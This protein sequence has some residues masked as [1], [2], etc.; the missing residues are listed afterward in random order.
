[1]SQFS[2]VNVIGAQNGQASE[3]A[4]QQAQIK[5]QT[6]QAQQLQLQGKQMATEAKLRQHEIDQRGQLQTQ[7]LS[8]QH[9]EAASGR[10]YEAAM[11]Q[12]KEQVELAHFAVEH[13]NQQDQYAFDMS[14]KMKLGLMTSQ[15]QN[16]LNE[17]HAKSTLA[18]SHYTGALTAYQMSKD[19]NVESWNHAFETLQGIRNARLQYDTQG[20]AASASGN[21]QTAGPIAGL[22]GSDPKAYVNFLR[23]RGAMMSLAA[24]QAKPGWQEGS[25]D[26]AEKQL[27]DLSVERNGQTAQST[28][29]R[30]AQAQQWL[31]DNR[32]Q[33]RTTAGT[34]LLQQT[35]REWALSV[36]MDAN[37]RP[38]FES[39]MARLGGALGGSKGDERMPE[40][41]SAFQQA[42][43]ASGH[44]FTANTLAQM[45]AG[46]K[47]KFQQMK[48]GTN[49]ESLVKS[50]NYTGMD[51]FLHQ[52]GWSRD[53]RPEEAAAKTLNELQPIYDKLDVASK[54][55]G[56]KYAADNPEVLGHTID[57]LQD[58]LNSDETQMSPEAK[59][60]LNA[61][62]NSARDAGPQY[63]G[64]G[65]GSARA[66]SEANRWAVTRGQVAYKGVGS[67]H[68]QVN[69]AQSE[70]DALPAAMADV[71]TRQGVQNQQFDDQNQRALADLRARA[72]ARYTQVTSAANAPI[73]QPGADA[74]VGQDKN[75][76]VQE[77]AWQ[78]ANREM[79]AKAM[80]A[81]PNIVGFTPNHQPIMRKMAVAKSL[82]GPTVPDEALPPAPPSEDE[83]AQSMVE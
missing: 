44:T 55:I 11:A 73:P 76:T 32:Q 29:S 69:T 26:T 34:G 58:V 1:M 35:A 18:D 79:E 78:Q 40:I 13:Q 16:D 31:D 81:N 28:T 45:A 54:V 21:T 22:W 19:R 50:M 72:D 2:H 47:D 57:H 10:Q 7:Q 9:T 33:I 66:A 39:A 27:N 5:Q 14:Q 30:Q 4:N 51:D 37:R 12:H 41:E 49:A 17:L 25:T 53:L 71:T 83:L 60:A 46:A 77:P 15:Q 62:I 56:T 38:A 70:K 80:K 6:L 64:V 36:G 68:G 3:L 61:Q 52:I 20:Y 65:A 82:A 42:V 67:A 43:E 8:A 23:N 48:E 74:N 59:D 75:G 24:G 63:L